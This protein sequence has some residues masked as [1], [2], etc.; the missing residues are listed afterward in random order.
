MEIKLIEEIQHKYGPYRGRVQ[1]K[2][3][4]DGV[5]KKYSINV[6]LLKA[7]KHLLKCK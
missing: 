5:V 4:I 1:V 3:S 7:L 2:M 6:N